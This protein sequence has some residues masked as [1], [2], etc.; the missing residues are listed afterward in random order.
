MPAL[1][2]HVC[3]PGRLLYSMTPAVT[4]FFFFQ[5]IRFQVLFYLIYFINEMNSFKKKKN[6]FSLRVISNF[7]V[8]LFPM[9]HLA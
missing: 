8:I 4:F 5:V 2:K 7:L 3:N 6:P 1:V 9:V